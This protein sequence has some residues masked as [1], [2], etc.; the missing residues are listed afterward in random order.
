MAYIKCKYCNEP[1]LIWY[2]DEEG[3]FKLIT[4]G[5]EEHHCKGS[6]VYGIRGLEQAEQHIPIV[7]T[8]HLPA[9]YLMANILTGVKNEVDAKLT[10]HTDQLINIITE[11][12]RSLANKRQE[13]IDEAVRQAIEAAEKR[14]PIKHLLQIKNEHGIIDI[15]GHPHK[16]LPKLVRFCNARLHIFLV[17]PAGGGKTTA[18]WQASQALSLPYYE[19]SMGPNTSQW[20]LA[21]YRSPDGRYI[22]GIMRKPYE[23]GGILMLDEIDNSN[24]SVL[25]TLNSALSNKGYQFPDKYVAKHQDFVCVAAGNTYGLGADRLYV[26]RNQLDAATLDRFATI[27]WDYDEDAERVWAGED[28]LSWTEYVQQVRHISQKHLMRVVVSP[29]ASIM[30]ARLLRCGNERQE[31]AESVLWKGMSREDRQKIGEELRVKVG[32]R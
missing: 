17:G 18:G 25:T 26:G 29:R 23:E 1:D 32:V 24:P 20:D 21:G 12:A 16:L 19:S 30:G 3:K 8:T 11:G 14:I 13:V 6:K 15:E 27:N 2:K 31:V 4:Q 5:G 10:E 7:D 9:P 28:Q 22:T